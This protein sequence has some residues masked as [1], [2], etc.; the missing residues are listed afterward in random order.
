MDPI[1]IPLVFSVFYIITVILCIAE[2]TS[3]TP[4]KRK[5]AIYLPSALVWIGAVG[6]LIFLGVAWGATL[7]GEG[8]GLTLLFGVF[9]LLGMSLMLAWKNHC[10]S[11]DKT[12]F[13]HRNFLGF[14]RSFTYDQV[15]SWEL[16]GSNPTESHIYVGKKKIPFSMTAKSSATFLTKIFDAYRKNHK[17]EHIPYHRALVKNASGNVGFRAHVH[18]PGEYL[19]ILIMILVI[20]LGAMIYFSFLSR[21]PVTEADGEAYSLSFDSW[22]IEKDR[23]E[24]HSSQEEHPF[25]ITPFEA[26]LT[27]IER[28]KENCNGK[29]VFTLWAKYQNPDDSKPYYRIL[30]LS[31][32]DVDYFT[33][34]DATA[35]H[36][37]NILIG[38][39]IL[40]ACFLFLLLFTLL[41]YFVGRNPKKFPEWVVY[42]C[43]KKNAIDID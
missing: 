38:Q 31:S 29:A 6:Y 26:Y 15:T 23:F 42:A 35:Q 12:G 3:R 4:E 13:V 17:G 25:V 30:A 33:F 8:F 22:S 34:E 37:K 40:G 21:N 27:N 16:N 24:L 9:T 11:F 43:F 32:G 19:G 1:I 5:N 2:A 36:R 7:A 14:T 41:A 28:L 18:N 10:V 20:C 39:V